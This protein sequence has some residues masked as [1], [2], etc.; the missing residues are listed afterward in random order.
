MKLYEF[1]I[2]AVDVDGQYTAI[3]TSPDVVLANDESDAKVRVAINA[4]D[5][6]PDDHQVVV[7]P[8]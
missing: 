3:H 7:R 1:V 4:E 6:D 8:F 5:F 2:V